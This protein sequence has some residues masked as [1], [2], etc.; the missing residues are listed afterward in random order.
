MKSRYWFQAHGLDFQDY[1]N[2]PTYRAHCV[3]AKFAA[4]VLS[5]S[6]GG[7]THIGLS[8]AA[9]QFRMLRPFRC[10]EANALRSKVAKRVLTE[11]KRIRVYGKLMRGLPAQ[12]FPCAYVQAHQEASKALARG[13]IRAYSVTS[14]P[15][16][17]RVIQYESHQG[18]QPDPVYCDFDPEDDGDIN[19]SSAW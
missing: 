6:G 3:T 1:Q 17:G 16:R 8:P 11:R 15:E 5:D 7:E 14:C 9:S 19:S 2:R 12:D 4:L 10:E 18:W 13:D